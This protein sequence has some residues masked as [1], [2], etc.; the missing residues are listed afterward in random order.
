MAS[1]FKIFEKEQPL[2]VAIVNSEVRVDPH[3]NSNSTL[4]RIRKG[5]RQIHLE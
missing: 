2:F 1:A 5:N 3:Q 4:Q